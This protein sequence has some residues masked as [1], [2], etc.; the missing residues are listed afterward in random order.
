MP[1]TITHAYFA[2]DLLKIL[3][4][5]TKESIKDKKR[6]LMMFAQS[7]DP[8]MFYLVS[9]ISGKKIRNLQHIAHTEKQMSFSLI[10][11]TS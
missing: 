10:Q 5:N 7:T 1:A 9:P 6:E 4:K 8:L 11:Y 3:N 2:E